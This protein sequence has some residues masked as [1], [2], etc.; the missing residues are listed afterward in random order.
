MTSNSAPSPVASSAVA[1]EVAGP[2]A[3]DAA[4]LTMRLD[5]LTR[6]I[7]TLEMG[8]SGASDLSEHSAKLRDSLQARF[9]FESEAIA[10]IGRD[11]ARGVAEGWL[12]NRGE[13]GARFSRIAKPTERTCNLSIDVVDLMGPAVEHAHPLGEITLGFRVAGAPLF[14]GYEPGWVVMP[15]GS[16]HIPQV[17]GGR[18]HLLYWLPQGRVD[19]AP[20]AIL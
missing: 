20:P 7:A 14:D 8:R 9:P 6:F 5:A 16:R 11:V 12:C 1:S 17:S 10:A 15:P 19:W 18:M 2:I 13:P 4:T 3:Q